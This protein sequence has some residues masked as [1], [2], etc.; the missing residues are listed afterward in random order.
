[1][2]EI[3]NMP[4]TLML[5]DEP[6][7]EL[8]LQL[9]RDDLTI[10]TKNIINQKHLP[11]FIQNRAFGIGH[12]LLSRAMP[13]NTRYYIELIQVVLGEF[14]ERTPLAQFILSLN[15]NAASVS[16]HYW[17]NPKT[18]IVFNYKKQ[19]VEFKRS[20]WSEINF[21]ENVRISEEINAIAFDD[22]FLRLTES[23]IS[24]NDPIFCTNGEKKKRWLAKNNSW[25]LEKRD[26]KTIID[27]ETHCF[28]F[29]AEREVLTPSCTQHCYNGVDPMRFSTPTIDNGIATIQKQC[30]SSKQAFLIPIGWYVCEDS[31]DNIAEIIRI[32]SESLGID[33]C[34]CKNFADAV[35]VYV[36]QHGYSQI[37][38]SNFGFLLS[39]DETAMPA[40]W[41]NIGREVSNPFGR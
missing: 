31:D 10:T 27:N 24:I 19:I 6:I 29:F 34:I 3:V 7:A 20:S 12:W 22:H 36:S 17:I 4:A 23:S 14:G 35:V 15:T 13:S 38:V 41:S 8:D 2:T 9:F 21:F 18:N 33:E 40:V 5:R 39:C 37:D 28:N 30:L 1:M 32:A 26:V 11:H 25:V 16:D